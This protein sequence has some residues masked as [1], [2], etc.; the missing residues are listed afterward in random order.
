MDPLADVFSVKLDLTVSREWLL[1]SSK[2]CFGESVCRC[3]FSLL[4]FQCDIQ[5]PASTRQS[6]EEDAQFC[7]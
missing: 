4:S 2:P 5:T 3:F 6:K 1:Q 7:L